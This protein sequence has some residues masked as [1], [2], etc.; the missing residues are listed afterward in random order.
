ML[1]S[2][3]KKR[4]NLSTKYYDYLLQICLLNLGYSFHFFRSK[5]YERLRGAA[6]SRYETAKK[7]GRMSYNAVSGVNAT[8]NYL[9]MNSPRNSR[10]TRSKGGRPKGGPGATRPKKKRTVSIS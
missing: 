4:R 6:R 3:E 2:F 1:L 9:K 7:D 8:V 10:Q 5:R